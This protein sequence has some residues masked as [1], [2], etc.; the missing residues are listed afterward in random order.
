MW[1]SV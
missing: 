1:C